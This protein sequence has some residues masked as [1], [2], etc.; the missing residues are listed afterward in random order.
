MFAVYAK[1]RRQGA[2]LAVE[3]KRA[4]ELGMTPVFQGLHADRA[5][6]LRQ[7]DDNGWV[8][9]QAWNQAMQIEAD[10]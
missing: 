1:I 4:T 2:K 5:T 3:T 7:I 9:V 6:A 8:R 10:K